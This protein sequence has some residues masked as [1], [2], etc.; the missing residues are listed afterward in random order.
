M[1]FAATTCVPHI[2]R[3]HDGG[4][5]WTRIVNGVN[6]MGPVNVVREDPVRRGLL[7]AGTER[8]VVFSAMMART[9]RRFG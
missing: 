6:P 1:R 7:F 8:E 9:G 5:T 3:T 4:R 2:Y